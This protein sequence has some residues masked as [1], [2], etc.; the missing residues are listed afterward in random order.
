MA[1][2]EYILFIDLATDYIDKKFLIK[3]IK[4]FIE[5][6]N[7]YGTDS[8]FGIVIFQEEENPITLYNS[9]DIASII[10]IIEKKWDKRPKNQSY[11]ENGL[12]EILS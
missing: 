10:K 4:S 1:S 2:E 9:K 11:I 3:E 12:F 8:S 6:K 7:T 5:N